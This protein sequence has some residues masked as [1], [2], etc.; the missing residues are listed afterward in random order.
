MPTDKTC[1][2]WG[3]TPGFQGSSPHKNGPCGTA[4]T[5]HAL[6]DSRLTEVR[7]IHHGHRVGQVIKGAENLE[8]VKGCASKR[9]QW[10]AQ[11]RLLFENF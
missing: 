4:S 7:E 6:A 3:E 9:R 8:D 2:R 10:Q 11:Q 1:G 5:V